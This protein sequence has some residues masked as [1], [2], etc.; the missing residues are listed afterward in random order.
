MEYQN[1]WG[2]A[3]V[4]SATATLTF[5][6]NHTSGITLFTDMTT[7]HAGGGPLHVYVS[8]TQNGAGVAVT[9]GIQP[10][11]GF[12]AGATN[13]ALGAIGSTSLA[14]GSS[15]SAST[16]NVTALWPPFWSVSVAASNTANESATM[17]IFIAYL[18]KP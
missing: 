16:A 10:L 8:Q 14:S 11:G 2:A 12:V 4:M 13:F 15:A 17:T 9:A 1:G 18:A 6:G 3:V 7:P 5:T